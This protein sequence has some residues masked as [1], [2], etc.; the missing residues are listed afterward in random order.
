MNE[1]K[2][3]IRAWSLSYAVQMNKKR[4]NGH[5]VIADAELFYQ[6]MIKDNKA[7]ILEIKNKKNE[8]KN[9]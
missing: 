8:V 3:D 5:E 4:K 6:Y 1:K 7:E 2:I 9:D